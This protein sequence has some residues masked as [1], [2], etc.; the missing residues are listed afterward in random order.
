MNDIAKATSNFAAEKAFLKTHSHSDRVGSKSPV[1][2]W[3]LNQ[4]QG[5]TGV[6]QT[7]SSGLTIYL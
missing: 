6:M 1:F 3:F 4:N 5:P 2:D 7:R